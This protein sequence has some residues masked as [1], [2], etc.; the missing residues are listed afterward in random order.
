MAIRNTELGGTDWVFETLN[1]V[2]LNDT[3]N[4]A[5][6]K[7]KTLSAFWLNDFLFD[8]YDD[9]EDYTTG[10]TPS[11]AK[12]GFSFSGVDG[13]VLTTGNGDAE[14]TTTILAGNDSK[15][16]RVIAYPIDAYTQ[17]DGLIEIKQV[18]A[19]KHIYIPLYFET[20]Q[21]LPSATSSNLVSYIHISF[22]DESSYHPIIE[23]LTR[24]GGKIEAWS[25]VLIVAKGGN[26]YDCY[27]SN[28]KVQTIT[29]TPSSLFLKFRG[30]RGDNTGNAFVHISN[31]KISKSVIS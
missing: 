7:I 5:T 23:T 16:L 22:D 29:S 17:G 27:I 18:S 8:L 31:I 12:W 4:A 14:I 25:D 6:E 28:R 2:D 15:E 20:F 9:F 26:E 10:V 13:G 3:F 24:R 21:T 30:I 1:A 19:N 11:S